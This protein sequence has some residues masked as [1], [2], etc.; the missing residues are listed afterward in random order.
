MP[1]AFRLPSLAA[2]H[3]QRAD[4]HEQEQPDEAVLAEHLE[5]DAVRGVDVE[6][7]RLRSG[8]TCRSR[9]SRS[10][11]RAAGRRARLNAIHQALMRPCADASSSYGLDRVHPLEP[12]GRHERQHRRCRRGTARCAM[13]NL[14]RLF[15]HRNAAIAAI[16]TSAPRE[17]LP[18]AANA[19]SSITAV[20]PHFCQLLRQADLH[21][22]HQR[23]RHHDRERDLVVA[24]DERALRVPR[25]DSCRRSASVKTPPFAPKKPS[26]RDDGPH[27]RQ[28]ICFLSWISASA[29]KVISMIF[30]TRDHMS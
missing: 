11:R 30:I 23:D 9:R 20:M 2:H 25:R 14:L 15:H 8:R 3:V 16:A 28:W 22:A 21:V 4:R 1:F 6:R 24:F 17:W 12:F 29:T 7:V 18:I 26:E 27:D 13:T 5:V 10:R 19:V